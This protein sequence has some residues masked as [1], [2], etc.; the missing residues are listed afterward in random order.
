MV[1]NYGD[2]EHPESLP[3]LNGFQLYLASLSALGQGGGVEGGPAKP[4]HPPAPLHTHTH[5]LIAAPGD[6]G[7]RGKV[8]EFGRRV[9]GSA[10][11]LDC[12]FK[13]ARISGLKML[14]PIVSW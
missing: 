9:A 12:L 11:S 4:A 7:V 1:E 2:K 6:Y 10:A 14:C 3:A 13:S 8:A 5:T